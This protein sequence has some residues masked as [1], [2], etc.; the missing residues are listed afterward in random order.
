MSSIL[1]QINVETDTPLG[2]SRC[3]KPVNLSPEV[4]EWVRTEARRK[5]MPMNRFL[6]RVLEIL[7]HEEALAAKTLVA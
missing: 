6:T 7:M 2:G 5:N 4:Y 1:D 3:L